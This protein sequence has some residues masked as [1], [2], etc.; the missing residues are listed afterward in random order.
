METKNEQKK[1]VK[2]DLIDLAN[3]AQEPRKKENIEKSSSSKIAST[4]FSKK[5]GR[6]HNAL[7]EGHEPGTTPGTRV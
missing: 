4:K 3:E 6:V 1:V 7:G 5:H 2:N